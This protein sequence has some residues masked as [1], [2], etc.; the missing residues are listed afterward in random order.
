MSLTIS[1]ANLCEH[2]YASISQVCKPAQRRSAA[3]HPMDAMCLHVELYEKAEHSGGFNLDA[4]P[5]SEE[6][7]LQFTKDAASGVNTAIL[8]L[9]GERG[10]FLSHTRSK[11]RLHR[12][13]PTFDEMWRIIPV[14]EE[15]TFAIMCLG[16]EEGFY[17]VHWDG[18]V[19]LTPNAWNLGPLQWH[20][21]TQDDG[22]KIFC[23]SEDSLKYLS[24]ANRRL[25]LQRAYRGAGELWQFSTEE[26][27]ES[28][29]KC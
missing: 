21:E 28:D 10:A 4:S 27:A 19:Y 5:D 22:Y 26:V 18:E 12:D 15:C 2:I 6:L 17:L 3:S 9:G 11:L 24:H 14:P 29:A 13:L 8:C 7:R 20:I 1:S 16:Q 25:F 23:F